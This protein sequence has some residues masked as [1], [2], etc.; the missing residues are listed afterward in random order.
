MGVYSMGLQ[1]TVRTA[2]WEPESYRRGVR[3]SGSLIVAGSSPQAEMIVNIRKEFIAKWNSVF[4]PKLK[5][6]GLISAKFVGETCLVLVKLWGEIKNLQTKLLEDPRTTVKE[7]LTTRKILEA[8]RQPATLADFLI[9]KINVVQQQVIEVMRKEKI[10]SLADLPDTVMMPIDFT[11]PD[12]FN[13]LVIQ[14]FDA[15]E[16]TFR[17]LEDVRS[18]ISGFLGMFGKGVASLIVGFSKTLN[19]VYD[20]LP[21]PRNVL[22]FVKI[23]LLIAAILAGGILL[24]V[25]V[26]VIRG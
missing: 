9:D 26:K 24:V 25:A 3:V 13:S 17:D 10:K 15:I 20:A 12:R 18:E 22:D 19:A 1:T 4:L 14:T 8:I 2:L 7:A 21:S 16:N 23:A 11:G 6:D 5:R